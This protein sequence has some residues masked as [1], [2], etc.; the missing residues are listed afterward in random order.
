[1]S[2]RRVNETSLTATAGAL[3]AKLGTSDPITWVENQGFKAAVESIQT[4]GGSSGP[5]AVVSV[6]EGSPVADFETVVN[7]GVVVSVTAEDPPPP[8]IKEGF[9][10]YNDVELPQIPADV[11][12]A[13]PYAW[14]GLNKDGVT[15][16]LVCSTD[17]WYYYTAKSDLRHQTS[18]YVWYQA[19]ADASAWTFKMSLTDSGPFGPQV[20]WSGYD[21][22]KDSVDS[23]N[24]YFAGSE[25]ILPS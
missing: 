8:Q 14:I 6:T 5:F 25:A 24:I 11:A 23:G 10:L 7:I 9:A 17:K 18:T 13:Y 20:I 15:Y 21:I 1:M 19:K 3:R 2:Q 16:N 22:H 4:G 12:A